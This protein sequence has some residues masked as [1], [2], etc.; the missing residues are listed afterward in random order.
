MAT[1]EGSQWQNSPEMEENHQFCSH[2]YWLYLVVCW[3]SRRLSK[4]EKAA[5][6]WL[7]HLEWNKIY[8]S[9][10]F[11]IEQTKIKEWERRRARGRETLF[12]YYLSN[13]CAIGHQNIYLD[14]HTPR[15]Q[16]LSQACICW[17]QV[18]MIFWFHFISATNKKQLSAKRAKVF[19]LTCIDNNGPKLAVYMGWHFVILV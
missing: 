1:V 13:D 6:Y 15:Q 10:L 8:Y 3:F 7:R 18:F 17:L 11:G 16:R 5:D 14:W 2:Y 12:W 19:A 9:K 4:R